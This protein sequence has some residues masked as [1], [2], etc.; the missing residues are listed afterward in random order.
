MF[1]GLFKRAERSID[2]VVARFVDRALVAV[3]LLVA[4]G[5]ATAALTVKLVEVYGH[6]TAYAMMAALFA[7]IGAVTMAVLGA[8]N[9]ASAHAHEADT[10]AEQDEKATESGDQ[11]S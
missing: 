10:E 3:P 5:F 2:S 1:Q 9:A 7:V 11:A 8:G 4:A 6:V